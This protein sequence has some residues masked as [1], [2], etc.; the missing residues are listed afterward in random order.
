VKYALTFVMFSFEKDIIERH[1]YYTHNSNKPTFFSKG[2][3]GIRRQ[4][5]DTKR[6]RILKELITH[7]RFPLALEISTGE[8]TWYIDR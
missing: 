4:E 6:L 8:H 5:I 7:S 1:T 2:V 3:Q